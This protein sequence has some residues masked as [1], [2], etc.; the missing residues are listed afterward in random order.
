M[1]FNRLVGVC[2]MI[3][4]HIKEISYLY[5]HS[6]KSNIYEVY[7][8]A[9]E[10]EIINEQNNINTAKALANPIHSENGKIVY[11]VFCIIQNIFKEHRN[12]RNNAPSFIYLFNCLITDQTARACVCVAMLFLLYFKCIKINHMQFSMW[13]IH[14]SWVYVYSM[15]TYQT[16]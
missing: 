5:A 16:V 2:V 10:Q 1:N 9:R 11:F 3:T 14:S 12:D 6:C 7:T 8:I 13:F 4:I 15:A